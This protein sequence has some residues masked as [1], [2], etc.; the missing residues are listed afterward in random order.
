MQRVGRM[1]QGGPE[2]GG[3]KAGSLGAFMGTLDHILGMAAASEGLQRGTG[4]DSRLRGPRGLACEANEVPPTTLSPRAPHFG[5]PL[6]VL[7]I[8]CRPPTAQGFRAG[9]PPPPTTPAQ[10]RALRLAKAPSPNRQWR[11]SG[12]SPAPGTRASGALEDVQRGPRSTLS[13]SSDDQ[14]CLHALLSVPWEAM[15]PRWRA[16]ALHIPSP[17]ASTC[18][19]RTHEGKS[20]QSRFSMQN[21]RDNVAFLS[22]QRTDQTPK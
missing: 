12:S 3:D 13:A 18:P 17:K 4:P 1:G 22:R 7:H 5:Q 15:C 8:F 20:L 9:W 14:N 10:D 16:R 11:H 6:W 21:A 19:G 2:R